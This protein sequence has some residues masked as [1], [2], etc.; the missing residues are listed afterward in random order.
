MERIENVTYVVKGSSTGAHKNFTM[1]Y[2][3]W[4]ENF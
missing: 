4:E 1:H 3:V 2:A